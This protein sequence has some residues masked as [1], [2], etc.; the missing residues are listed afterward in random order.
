MYQNLSKGVTSFRI[1]IVENNGKI[2]YSD[3]VQVYYNEPGKY[4]VFPVPVKRNQKIE[5]FTS[6]PNE[7]VFTLFDVSGRIVL[8]KQ[9][10]SAHEYITTDKLSP[11]IYFYRIIKKDGNVSMG[12]VAVF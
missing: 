5:I 1:R 6:F 12:K 2:I 9:I 10:Q 8:K 11:G 3:K 7:E 4:L